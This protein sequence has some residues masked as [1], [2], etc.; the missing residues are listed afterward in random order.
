MSSRPPDITD[1][2]RHSS[3]KRWLRVTTQVL[4]FVR[5]VNDHSKRMSFP[6]CPT[7]EEKVST[8]DTIIWSFEGCH[9]NL[10]VS[11]MGIADNP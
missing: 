1:V 11:R 8:V 5:I 3:L 2:H 6:S 10:E 4:R 9:W 7:R